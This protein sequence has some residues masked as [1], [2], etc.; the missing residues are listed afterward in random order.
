MTI[1]VGFTGSQGGMKSEQVTA[2]RLLLEEIF[3]YP[4]DF[5]PSAPFADLD[6]P[7][8]AEL[9]HGDCIGS[10]AQAHKIAREL[11]YRVVGHP[12]INSSKR[13]FCDF[14]EL[15]EPREYLIRNHD[16]VDETNVMVATPDAPETLRSGTWA[17]IRYA[18]SLERNIGVIYTNE[19]EHRGLSRREA[20]K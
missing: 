7:R 9:H 2:L 16:I 12:P 19:D 13:A 10:D 8:V 15:R 11:G 20:T 3:R 4:A 6:L 17:T 18:R 14:D 5:L 1:R